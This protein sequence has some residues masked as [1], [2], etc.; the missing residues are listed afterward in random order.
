VYFPRAV[1]P[2]KEAAK[3]KYVVYLYRDTCTEPLWMLNG[4]IHRRKL[5]EDF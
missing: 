2:Q 3:N 1:Y 4:N 5:K